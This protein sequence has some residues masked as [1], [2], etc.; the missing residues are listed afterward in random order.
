MFVGTGVSGGNGYSINILFIC[1][2]FMMDSD[3]GSID[4]G[5]DSMVKFIILEDFLDDDQVFIILYGFLEGLSV[6]VI[7]ILKSIVGA[8]MIISFWVQIEDIVLDIFK[9]VNV[10]I[11]SVKN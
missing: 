4:L 7:G 2:D 10:S 1:V 8:N 5:N 6:F 9:C 3:L 11:V